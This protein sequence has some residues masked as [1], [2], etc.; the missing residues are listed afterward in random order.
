M[1]LACQRDL[2]DISDGV[3]Y[4]NTAYMSPLP[5]SV[6]EA[7]REG[8][9][10]K[11]H[12]WNILGDD[13]FDP[14]EELRRKFGRLV[15]DVDGEGTAIIPAASY[16][17]GVAANAVSVPAGRSILV[18]A[19]QF[20]SNVYPWRAV[21]ERDGGDVRT[22]PRPRDHDWTAALLEEI[23]TATA[24]VAV[25]ACHWSDGAPVDLRVVG[26]AARAVGAV[27]VVDGIQWIG[28]AP[29][30]V[31]EIRPDFVVGAAYKWLLGPYS[32]CYLWA[33][34]DRRDGAPLEYG[35]QERARSDDFA[36]LVEYTDEF[37]PGARR[38][39]MG[40]V[41]NF[42]LT[43]AAIAGIDLVVELGVDEIAEYSR[44]LMDRLLDGA[45][46]LGLRVPPAGLRSP[47]LT[48]LGL[49]DGVDPGEIGTRLHDA[50]VYVSV[51]GTSIRVSTHIYNTT[52]D[53]DRLLDVLDGHLGT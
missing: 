7:G 41:S 14:P 25:P 19:E 29:F 27:F 39:D 31:A 34:H 38:Y 47:H 40:E 13:F 33:A 30:D 51:R 6:F 48:G 8:L 4:L 42:A 49:P 2:F 43:P 26:E 50:G 18:L 11:L 28:A 1:P 10:D 5:L 17:V 20:P 46:R 12:P 16:G 45:S 23:D 32:V 53:V 36:R 22:V 24:V 35:W 52:N 3:A 37:R 44:S 21:A 9:A 15:G